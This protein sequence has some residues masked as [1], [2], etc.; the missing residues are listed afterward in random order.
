MNT[1]ALTTTTRATIQFI[2]AG[3]DS[4]T[5]SRL[6]QFERWLEGTG[7]DWTTPDLQAYQQYLLTRD[8]DRTVGT[9]TRD[10]GAHKKGDPIVRHYG[11]VAARSIRSYVGTIR[12]RYKKLLKS[13]TV[14]DVLYDMAGAELGKLGEDD[15]P[16]T[17]KAFVD[18]S[19]ERLKNGTA[20]S[21][22]DVKPETKQD[23]V[24]CEHGTRLTRDQANA[25]LA[26]PGLIPIVKLRDTCILGLFLAT[27]IREAELANLDVKDLRQTKD[28]ELCLHVR[29]GKGDKT[30]IVFYGGNEWVLAYLDRWLAAAGIESGA[31]FR[32]F[33]KGHHTLRS[34]RLTTRAIQKIVANY[35]VMIGG[36]KV[37]V[38]PHDLRRSYARIWYDMGSDLVGLKQ[39]LGH[40]SLKTTLGYVGL[41][42]AEQR[43]PPSMYSPP[44][45]SELASVEVQG[46]LAS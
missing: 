3:A 28:G 4:G 8:E 5:R 32:G 15:T 13:N 27:G 7:G 23:T 34:G 43:K 37:T 19:L 42:D 40:T 30:R 14:R 29:H 16:V 24:D 33:Y 2:P 35:P 31:V 44:H 22:D 10:N 39:N 36:E 21:D 26:S 45:W 1:M 20:T 18:E 25:L 46:R 9:Y 6:Q 17:R 41:L 11:P 12:G 38:H